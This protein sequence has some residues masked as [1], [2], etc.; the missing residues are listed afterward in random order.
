MIKFIRI[1]L[2]LALYANPL[3]AQFLSVEPNSLCEDFFLMSVDDAK[4]Q[5]LQGLVL[6]NKSGNEFS[7]DKPYAIDQ[8]VHYQLAENDTSNSLVPSIALLRWRKGNNA[9][10]INPTLDLAVA[11]YGSGFLQQNGRGVSL[12]THL[13]GKISGFAFAEENQTYLTDYANDFRNT[14]GVIPGVGFWKNFKEGGSDYFRSSGYLAG[15]VFEDQSSGSYTH[16]TFG[17]FNQK[18]GKGIRSLFLGANGPSNLGLRLVTNLN[19]FITYTNYFGQ[20]N[21][22]TPLV[23]NVLLPKKYIASHR[24]GMNL[25]AMKQW[26]IGLF[27]SVIHSRNNGAGGFDIDYLNPIIFYR[28]VESNLG[29]ADNALVGLD[30]NY[31]SKYGEFYGQ[32][33]I[34]EFKVSELRKNW[35]ANKYG[36]QLGYRHIRSLNRSYGH[37]AQVEL[38]QVRPYTY[39]HYNPLNAYSHYNQGLAHPY[40]A[41]LRE[42]TGK[43]VAVFP[44]L[45]NTWLEVNAMFLTQ[46]LDTFMGS[47]NMGSN[48]RLSNDTRVRD[49][50]VTMFQ[51][52]K[53]V[54]TSLSISV[55]KMISHQFSLNL[56]YQYRDESLVARKRNYLTAGVKYQIHGTRSIL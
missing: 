19:G 14:L 47:S 23:G 26:G 45:S 12:R 20:M 11:N 41:N 24:L 13:F 55:G 48:F 15:N 9:I 28:S 27:E 38:N 43:Y 40:G 36:Y 33:I 35:W 25:G 16:L 34:D 10:L 5:Q 31:N 7:K 37:I 49:Y 3:A 21:G 53:N 1:F 50:D 32:L 54:T 30:L 51:G 2:I 44:K 22:F 18:F 39:S 6:R 4:N 8:F 56:G 17:H 52:N 42:I 46:G 29:S